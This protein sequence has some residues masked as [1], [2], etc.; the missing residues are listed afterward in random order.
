MFGHRVSAMGWVLLAVLFLFAVFL[1]LAIGLDALLDASM[2]RA[3]RRSLAER[4]A[5]YSS[6]NVAEEAE[7]WLRSQ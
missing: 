2:R 5:A 1:V 6:G 4:L 3:T 7:E